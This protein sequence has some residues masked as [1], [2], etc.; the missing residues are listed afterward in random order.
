MLIS[1]DRPSAC[2]FLVTVFQVPGR[3]PGQPAPLEASLEI[4]S[5][6]GSK[7]RSIHA[8][9]LTFS[10]VGHSFP[11]LFAF[12]AGTLTNGTKGLWTVGS[13]ERCLQ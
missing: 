12:A 7:S 6:L 9:I 5:A 13:Q 2:E 8:G 3:T 11:P 4:Q 10:L 1:S